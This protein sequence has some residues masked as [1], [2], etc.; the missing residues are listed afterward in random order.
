MRHTFFMSML[1]INYPISDSN[2]QQIAYAWIGVKQE[3]PAV[4]VPRKY[5]VL[6]ELATASAI[7]YMPLLMLM[8]AM[9]QQQRPRRAE[10]PP[11]Q[12]PI[13]EHMAPADT[14]EAPPMSHGRGNGAEHVII[15]PETMVDGGQIQFGPGVNLS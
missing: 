9:R 6:I 15:E 1:G 5:A 12:Q 7:T 13:N 8:R 11:P 2:A 10:P 4:A 3:Y 14:G